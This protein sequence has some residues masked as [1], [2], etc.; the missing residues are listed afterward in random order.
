M[1]EEKRKPDCDAKDW[2]VR[3]QRHRLGDEKPRYKTTSEVL[4]E[5]DRWVARE[6]F[7]EATDKPGDT[8]TAGLSDVLDQKAAKAPIAGGVL[9]LFP[10]AMHVLAQV[11]RAGAK[12][13]G[14]KIGSMSYLEIPDAYE[15]YTDALARHLVDEK[16]EGPVNHKDG[17]LLHPAQAAWSALARLEIFLEQAEKPHDRAK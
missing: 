12:K 15:A 9:R 3:A 2:R 14:V 17:G 6:L 4:A 7:D 13:Y 1:K 10:R 16:L 8:A 5:R 11:S